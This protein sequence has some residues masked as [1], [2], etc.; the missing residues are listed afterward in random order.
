MNGWLKHQLDF[1]A[2]TCNT[3]VIDTENCRISEPSTVKLHPHTPPEFNI[4]QNGGWK[5][6]FLLGPAN[7][8]GA[9]C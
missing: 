9:N 7:F 6:S 2:N 1:L 5:T 4:A 3:M 8:S